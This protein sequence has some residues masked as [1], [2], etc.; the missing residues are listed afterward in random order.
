MVPRSGRFSVFRKYYKA[1]NGFAAEMSEDVAERVS[2]NIYIRKYDNNN[3]NNDYNN[4]NNNN[5][6][7]NN[8]DELKQ[9]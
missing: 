6:S 9:K 4:N 2:I 7:N 1:L 3:N 8:S 5:S